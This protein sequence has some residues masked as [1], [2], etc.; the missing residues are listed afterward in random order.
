M[1]SANATVSGVAGR[2][3]TPLVGELIDVFPGGGLRRGA[4]R[5]LAIVG[6]DRTEY[7]K[8]LVVGDPDQ[9]TAV[10]R[11]AVVALPGGGGWRS[12]STTS[13]ASASR[14]SIRHLTERIVQ[15]ADAERRQTRWAC[16]TTRSS[17]S[18]PQPCSSRS[19]DVATTSPI[20]PAPIG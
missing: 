19:S 16:T 12:C 20:R 2:D 14:I 11:R 4:G 1:W 9:P 7:L 17:R 8:D 10:Y 18:R 13:R 3:L 15:L 6:T 5:A